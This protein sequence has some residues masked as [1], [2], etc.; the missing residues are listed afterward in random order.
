MDAAKIAEKHSAHKVYGKKIS[1]ES[2]APAL[3][4][5]HRWGVINSDQF[6]ALSGYCKSYVDQ[7]LLK[8][9]AGQGMIRKIVPTYSKSNAP[10]FH[11]YTLLR[12]GYETLCGVVERD[13][14]EDPEA[15]L[16][17]FSK[18]ADSFHSNDQTLHHFQTLDLLVAADQQAEELTP[19]YRLVEQLAEWRWWRGSHYPTALT[20]RTGDRHKADGGLI[21]AQESDSWVDFLEND[22]GT[23]SYSV[24]AGKI[25]NYWNTLGLDDII[26]RFGV[27]M[28]FFRVLFITT[29]EDRAAKMA[30]MVA[31]AGLVPFCDIDP[32]DV[33]YFTTHERAL[34]DF[35]G[36]HWRTA[37]EVNSSIVLGG[38]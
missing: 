36:A 12:K 31:E 11:L 20:A 5:M 32:G 17:K 33:F 14:N 10:R 19:D 29:T 35:Y 4:A 7:K 6:A 30:G 15:A 37:D 16:G 24:I 21:V 23:E 26:T 1:R 38:A 18:P 13:W 2:C 8:K 27:S 25:R 28:P 22:N 34:G 9:L 3:L